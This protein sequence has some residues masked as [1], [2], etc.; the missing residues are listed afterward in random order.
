[1]SSDD[2]PGLKLEQY[3]TTLVVPIDGGEHALLSPE[4]GTLIDGVD[5][6]PDVSAVDAPSR[7][8]VA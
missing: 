5:K 7:L 2:R 3:G 1:M 6:A 4:I 8:S